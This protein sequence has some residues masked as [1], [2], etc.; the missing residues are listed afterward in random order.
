MIKRTSYQIPVRINLMAMLLLVLALSSAPLAVHAQDVIKLDRDDPSLVTYYIHDGDVTVDREPSLGGSVISI[1]TVDNTFLGLTDL[2]PVDSSVRPEMA[3]E[4]SASED[5]LTWTFKLRTDVP[6]VHW[7]PDTQEATKMRNVT[8]QDVVTGVRRSCDGRLGGAYGPLTGVFISG[9]ADA[10]AATEPTQ[11][12]FEAIG[13]TAV[14]DA[15][16]EFTL[17]SPTGFFPSVASLWTLRPIP[18]ELVEEF[19]SAWIEPG[20]AW[21]NGVFLQDTYTPA[22]GR[23]FIRNPFIPEDLRGPGNIDRVDLVVINEPTT[24][25]A[26]Y[27]N[28]QIDMVRANSLPGGELGTLL[29]DASLEDQLLFISG[30]NIDYLGFQMGKPPFDNVY[31]RRAFSAAI[32][33][34][35]IINDAVEGLGTPLNHL[36]PP[37]MPAAPPLDQHG[38]GY[39]PEWAVEQLAQSPYPNCEG[40]PEVYMV[41]TVGRR[42]LYAEFLPAAWSNILGCDPSVFRVEVFDDFAQLVAADNVDN[43]LETRPHLILT[44][45]G[46]DYPD[47]NNYTGDILYCGIAE[48]YVGRPC[49]EVDELIEQARS[50]TDQE[51]RREMYGQIE[52]MFFGPEGLFPVAPIRLS[53]NY[54][55]YQSYI[56]GPIETDG[57]VGGEHWGVYTIDKAAQ[58]AVRGS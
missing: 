1:R 7:N 25:L 26:A 10:L 33:R 24:L 58:D 44:G 35:A 4:W 52:D 21:F 48:Q 23:T 53:A 30:V 20:N 14:D 50:E 6:W 28:G 11:E 49:S 12:Q 46:P 45:W 36:T 57:Q 29:N 31:V 40:F 56:D 38:V 13:V 19:G 18:G 17:N 55:L 27:L 34:V 39:D 37:S 15:T 22:V 2:D 54:A 9:C 5:G 43:P 32:D 8:A 47:A 41:A 16:I 51:K 42:A 3:T